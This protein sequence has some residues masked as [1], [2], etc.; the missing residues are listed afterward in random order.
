MRV[1]RNRNKE[2]LLFLYLA[3]GAPHLPNEAPAEALAQ[4][5]HIAS[6]KRRVHAAMVSE[7]DVATGKLMDELD[8]QGIR[9]DYLSI[10]F[11]LS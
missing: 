7:M 10:L 4:Y 9:D 5:A 6:E 3:L 1:V 2:K 8:V 11:D